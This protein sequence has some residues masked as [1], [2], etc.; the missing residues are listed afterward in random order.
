MKDQANDKRSPI[1]AVALILTIGF[2]AL[3]VALL[4][5]GKFPDGCT[6]GLWLID[7]LSCLEPNALGDTFA[8][9]FAPV[10]FVWL[11]AAV[12]LQRSELAA[13]R[14]ELGLTRQEYK[15]TREE[16]AAQRAAIQEQVLESRKNVAF[17]EEQTS[18]LKATRIQDENR[19]ADS[20]IRSL[21]KIALSQCH[22]TIS[23]VI[24]RPVDQIEN[25]TSR[26]HLALMSWSNDGGN[27]IET[28][29]LHAESLQKELQ[30]FPNAITQTRLEIELNP[31]RFGGLQR[32]IEKI[33]ELRAGASDELNDSLE[34]LEWWRVSS[35]L[36]ELENF[37]ASQD[38]TWGNRLA[39]W[40]AETP[41]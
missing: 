27:D 1:I 10:A 34:Y 31:E 18:I 14:Q 24:A 2:L 40:R 37:L 9:A 19:A 28:V 17:V 13:Q 29:V 20:R 7:R 16:V 38:E 39:E 6:S 15:L 36:E 21:A 11:V 3:F 22:E 32:T 23:V 41:H 8:G 4:S 33:D 30:W 35:T 26:G 12:M 25:E 5:A